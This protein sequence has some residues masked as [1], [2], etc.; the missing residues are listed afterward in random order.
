MFSGYRSSLFIYFSTFILLLYRTL[1]ADMMKLSRPHPVLF[2]FFFSHL[3]FG[4]LSVTGS[5]KAKK[6]SNVAV[7]RFSHLLHVCKDTPVLAEFFLMVLSIFSQITNCEVEWVAHL[8]L[9]LDA[10]S[11]S[12]PSL[13]LIHG[14]SMVTA[15]PLWPQQ[16]YV[17]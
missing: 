6:K 1:L 7:Q 2:S 13:R 17:F 9:Y 5:T 10:V 16:G 8:F 15:L 14:W 12:Y 3:I 4:L 11:A